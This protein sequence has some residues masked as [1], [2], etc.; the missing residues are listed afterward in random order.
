MLDLRFIRDNLDLVKENV[1]FRGVR[2]ADPE[3]V[4]ELYGK[5][6]HLQ[7]ELEALRAERN[8]SSQKMKGKIEQEERQKL[9]ERGRDLKER[10]AAL[11]P[12]LEGIERE[13]DLAARKIPNMTH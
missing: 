4:S 7:Q 11:E 10:I 13:L 3:L 9:I 2:N 1:A 12:E 8:E 6:L 5:R